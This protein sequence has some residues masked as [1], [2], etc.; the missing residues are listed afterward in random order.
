MIKA[1]LI[2]DENK[3]LDYLEYQLKDIHGLEV[4]G[5][6]NEPLEGLKGVGQK[7]VDLVFLDIKMPFMN[8]TELAKKMLEK[9]PNLS[10][11]FITAY[12]EYAVKAFNLNAV[13]YIL[14]PVSFERLIRSLKRLNF[15]GLEIPEEYPQNQLKLY[16][17]LF[18]DVSFCKYFGNKKIKINI[19]WRTAKTLEL[20]LYMLN[21]RGTIMKK[22]V[23]AKTI[24]PHLTQDRAFKQL[25][26][27]IYNIRFLLGEYNRNFNITTEL[28]GYKMN[29]E[30]ITIDVDQFEEIVNKNLPISNLTLPD[31]EKAIAL[32]TGEYLGENEYIWSDEEKQKYELKWLDLAYRIVEYYQEQKDFSN[33]LMVSLKICQMF[34]IE[35][36]AHFNIM[37]IYHQI[38]RV[39][40]VHTHYLKLKNIL[41]VELGSEPDPEIT[42]W[43][44]NLTREPLP[45]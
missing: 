45:H 8:G 19:N 44:D 32:Y 25:Y 12:N 33:A 41:M 40:M 6:Y 9:K 34:P 4:V 22:S 42:N 21:N 36:D 28:A 2:D 7:E 24:W 37:K 20:F 3:A 18:R 26:N 5:K 23:I 39:P 30:N 11:I 13:D 38:G 16:V 29:V 17:N 27:S 1:I 14:K 35:E 10:I 43:Y 31:Y 15:K